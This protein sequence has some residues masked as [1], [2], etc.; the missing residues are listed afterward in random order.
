MI[1]KQWPTYSDTDGNFVAALP[2]SAIK[3]YPNGDAEISF[4]G[5]YQPI[6]VTASF[7]GIWNPVVGGYIIQ[8]TGEYL[9]L[10]K[11]EFEAKYT[12]SGGAA[13]AP[14][15]ITGATP[16][17]ISLLTAANTGAAQTA[18]GGGTMGKQVFSAEDDAT[19]RT[20]IKAA[21]DRLVNGTQPGMMTPQQYVKVAGLAVSAS[22]ASTDVT[23]SEVAFG[24]DGKA[25][26]VMK[27]ADGKIADRTISSA[28]LSGTKI[29]S[30]NDITSAGGTITI[31]KGTTHDAALKLLADAVDPAAS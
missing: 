21:I 31:P 15:D 9:Y 24:A 1:V 26:L 20:L 17:G 19:V 6:N 12:A 5:G 23:A 13:V 30:A 14:G 29:V 22:G 7:T 10:S 8:A 16:T 3:Q 25:V 27:I 11:A 4:A 2:I 18:L 28:G